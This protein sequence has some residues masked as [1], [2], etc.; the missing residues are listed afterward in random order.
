MQQWRIQRQHRRPSVL[1]DFRFSSLQVE[2]SG[3]TMCAGEAELS[4]VQA[5]F[6]CIDG[7][8]LAIK[9]SGLQAPTPSTRRVGVVFCGRQAPGCHDLLCGLT[10]MLETEAGVTVLGFVGGTR[11]LFAKQAIELTPDVCKPFRYAGGLE[12]LGRT[13]DRIN[14]PED[15]KQAKDTCVEMGLSG[16]VLVGGARTQT[17]AA[18]LAEY[19]RKQEVDT[20]VVGVPVGM[21]GSMINEFVEASLGFDSA[22]KGMA[23]LVGNTAIDGSSARKYYYFLKLMDGSATGC[24]VPTSHVAVEAALQTRPNMLLLT[25]EVDTR[26]MT[27]RD[28]VK[29][30]ADMVSTRAKDGKHFGTI[31]VAEGLLAAIPEFHCLITELEAMPHS[32]VEKVLE[33]LTVWS[34][35]LFL[36]LPDFM[37]R[38]LLLERQSNAALQLSQLETE[39]LVACLVE[40]ELKQRTKLG[41]YKGSFSPV[42]QFLGYQARCGMPSNFDS[43]YGYTLGGAAGFLAASRKSGYMAIASDLSRPVEEW[44]VGGVP[45]T[46]MIR[47]DKHVSAQD[48]D[49]PRPSIPARPVDLDGAAFKAWQEMRPACARDELY[50]NPGPIQMSGNTADRVAATITTRFNYLGG[51]STL[52]GHI[53]TVSARCRPGCDPRL[54]RVANQS[55]STLLAILSEIADPN[56]TVELQ[57]QTVTSAGI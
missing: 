36:S 3:A 37:Q 13:V 43:D 19:L 6:S 20:A 24:K 27:L 33:E 44:H 48:V 29:E 26:R 15:L 45:F 54:L 56:S 51:L 8:L 55:L 40:E 16:L 17:D 30:V 31:I 1:G 46:A 25:E 35:A 32:A 34:R 23:H 11:G 10:D 50:E 42:C 14:S 2:E 9:A 7:P 4:A 49:L 53:D 5:Y 21:E 39:R 18:Y 28:V 22:A 38:E 52:R 47:A 57:R 41:T 12:L